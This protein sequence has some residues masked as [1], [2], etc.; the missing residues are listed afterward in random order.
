MG[1]PPKVPAMPPRSPPLW[2]QLQWTAK[3]V[4]D[5]RAGHSLATQLNQ[6]P[7][8]LRP[9]LQA[10]TFHVLRHLGTATAV[11]AQLVPKRPPPEADAVLCTALALMLH[12]DGERYPLHTLADQAVEAA[13]RGRATRNQAGLINACI[14]RF[15]R[16]YE[17]ILSAVGHDPVASWNHPAWWVERLRADHPQAWQAVLQQAQ[18]AAPMVLRVNRLRGTAADAVSALVASGIE[19]TALEGDAIQLARPMPVT[20]IPGFAEGRL[21]VQSAAAQRAAP[22]LLSGL[23]TGAPRILDACAAPGGKTAHLLELCPQAHVMALEV[24]AARS[25]RIAG[26]LERLGLQ[27]QIRIAD[28]ATV[29]NWWDGEPFDR[30]M[31]DAPCSASGIVRR[32]PDIRWLRRATDIPQLAVQQDR[33]LEAL[34][35]LLATGGRLLYV[36]CSVFREEGA[37]RVD[38]FLARH[39]DAGLLSSPG[40]VLPGAYSA[41]PA[42]GEN[43]FCDDGFFYALLEK[44][45]A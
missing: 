18:Q 44:R 4:Q 3:L 24:D 13:K 12:V 37:D 36:T 8:D 17:Q 45:P 7:S 6:V 28:A 41:G 40:H 43:A 23:A 16:E 30:I 34:W 33:L 1:A 22:L 35:P 26:T 21:S 15:A 25:E 31:L 19:A 32:H 38:A 9:G 11:R 5:V 14:R 29:S 2:Q 10:L 27:A 39:R 20:A 42:T